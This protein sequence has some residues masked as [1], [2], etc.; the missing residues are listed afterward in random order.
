MKNLAMAGVE[1]EAVIVGNVVIILGHHH[2]V[3]DEPGQAA[4]VIVNVV[5]GLGHHH[6]H[7]D[8]VDDGPGQAAVVLVNVVIG[9]GPH[10]VHMDDEDDEPGQGRYWTKEEEVVEEVLEANKTEIKDV[11]G[12][13][14]DLELIDYLGDSTPLW[15]DSDDSQP[16]IS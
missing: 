4:V 1:Q 9:I 15:I 13:N 3:D 14:S 2:D 12:D 16:P 8:E 7:V 11:T 5:I 10:H 6:V